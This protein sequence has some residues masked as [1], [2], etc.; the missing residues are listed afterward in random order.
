MM[1]KDK[2]LLME[3]NIDDMNPQIFEYLIEELIENNALDAFLQNIIMKKGRPAVKLSVICKEIDKE[4][5]AKIIFN[6]TSTIGIRIF[7]AERM[8]LSRKVVIARTKYGNISV[9]ISQTEG[10]KTISP[11]YDECKTF[12][13]KKKVPLKEV[14]E[15][16]KRTISRGK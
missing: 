15:E 8:K 10:I 7:P 1:E 13:R 5:I 11:E 3:A 16:A 14:I 9:K 12:A 2:V 4:R 6:E